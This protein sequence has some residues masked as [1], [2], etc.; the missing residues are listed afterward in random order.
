MKT[1][2]IKIALHGVSPMIWR[3]IRLSGS[4]SV[5]RLHEIIQLAFGWDNDHL[6]Q[7]HIYG[8]DY[9]IYYD[10]GGTFDDNA[11]EV[12][13][14]SFAFDVG[15]KFT[16]EYNF[17]QHLLHDIRVEKVQE[18]TDIIAPVCI[19]GSGMVGITK[20]SERD[21]HFKVIKTI[22]KIQEASPAKELL[23]KDRLRALLKEWDAIIFNRRKLNHKL[24]TIGV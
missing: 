22:M 18:S 20:G 12:Y 13:L 7:F 2:F 11:Y 23:I 1:Y 19:S 24:A 15:D 9:G 16:Y 21:I 17:F 4:T 6:H 14:D 3:R 5:A 8:K 10:G